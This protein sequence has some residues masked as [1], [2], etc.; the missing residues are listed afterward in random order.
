ML[1]YFVFV[2]DDRCRGD[3]IAWSALRPF[4]SLIEADDEAYAI[5]WHERMYYN[6]DDDAL[7]VFPLKGNAIR[8]ALKNTSFSVIIR[9]IH[10]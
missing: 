8:Y 4:Y 6:F 5:A 3:E 10:V 9:E 7:K 1:V 2:L